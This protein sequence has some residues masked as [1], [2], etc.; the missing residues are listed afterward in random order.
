[1]TTTGSSPTTRASW[2]DGRAITSPGRAP[3]SV[4]SGGP[5]VAAAS[6][7]ALVAPEALGREPGA[8]GE[9]LEL[10]PDDGRMDLWREGGPGREAAVGARQ[11]V[12][13][14]HQ[15][16]VRHDLIR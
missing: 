14:A 11:D 15:A 4:P 12:L 13:A 3:N 2:P 5:G 10:G 1:M 6:S 8:V 9:R 7:K 16:G